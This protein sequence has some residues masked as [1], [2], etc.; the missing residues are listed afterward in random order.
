MSSSKPN[1][2]IEAKWI[3]SLVGYD[4]YGRIVPDPTL[5]PKQKYGVLTSPR[6]SWFVNRYE[7]LKQFIE[8]TNAVLSK[9]LIVDSK[10]ISNLFKQDPIPSTVTNLYD[11]SVDTKAELDLLGVAKAKQAKMQ[12]TVKDGVIVS[13]TIIDPGRGYLTTP[14]FT[15]S[16]I[17]TGADFKFT[18][19]NVGAI[20]NVEILNGGSNYNDETTVEIRKYT[21]L[22]NADEDIQGKWALYE[23]NFDT[24]NWDRFRSQAYNTTL[25]WEYKDWYL[26]GYG[27]FSEPKFTVDFSYEL[28]ALDDKINDIVKINNIGS[29]GWLLLRK[30][31]DQSDVDYTVNYQTIG[32]QDGTI[33]FKQTLYN[34]AI[35]FDGFDEI[36]FDTKFYDPLPT[37]E[38]RIIAKAIK[39]D[40]FIEELEVEYNKLFFA[41]IRY[42]LSE[43]LYV[44]WLF[45]TSFIKA[46]HNVGELRKDITF[47]NDNLPSY[48]DYI[49]EVKPFKTKLREYVS[50]YEKLENSNT[51]T[52]DFDLPL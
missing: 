34:T 9:E 18:L 10:N 38:T 16:G 36:S 50:S 3:D 25:Y 43:Q 24:N 39:E 5:G 52:T 35:S 48:Q 22:V 32:R 21:V 26:S 1:R 49:D 13:T 47:N 31:D 2:D 28:D 19:N 14:T 33:N 29:G 51:L 23:R 42:V 41:S 20:V 4:L 15:I 11:T 7:A 27:V 40:I 37:T 12:V 44:D 8:K 45:K 6:Q 46:K 17:G 30:I